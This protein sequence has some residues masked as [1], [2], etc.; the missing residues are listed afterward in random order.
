MATRYYGH[1]T[2]GGAVLGSGTNLS[3]C[4]NVNLKLKFALSNPSH[5]RGGGW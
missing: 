2:A 4:I 5:Q 3:T 1:E